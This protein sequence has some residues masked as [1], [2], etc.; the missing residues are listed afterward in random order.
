MNNFIQFIYTQKCEWW[1]NN[2]SNHQITVAEYLKRSLDVQNWSYERTISHTNYD[3]TTLMTF[4]FTQSFSL[5]NIQLTSLY[6][7]NFQSRMIVCIYSFT[8]C[9]RNLMKHGA[10]QKTRWK[11]ND[12]Q[13][14]KREND[15]MPPIFQ[16]I[17]VIISAMWKYAIPLERKIFQTIF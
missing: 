17:E 14:I 10:H 8:S 5:P 6:E 15:L 12:P 13:I 9:G 1:G 2:I 11:K 4:F 3:L 16:L 7:Y